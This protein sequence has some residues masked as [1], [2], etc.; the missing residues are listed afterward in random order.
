[1]AD[2]S[3]GVA[4]TVS[5]VPSV[6]NVT[7]AIDEG[8]RG[9]TGATGPE[10]PAGADGGGGGDLFNWTGG[11]NGAIAVA[12]YGVVNLGDAI[13]LPGLPDDAVVGTVI[14]IE[15]W[16]GVGYH[17]TTTTANYFTLYGG[18]GEQW[19]NYWDIDRLPSRIEYLTGYFTRPRDGKLTMEA[20]LV[21]TAT[22]N[23]WSLNIYLTLYY[24]DGTTNAQSRRMYASA[25]IYGGGDD[26]LP[27]NKALTI[28]NDANTPTPF[29]IYAA[30]MRRRT[31]EASIAAPV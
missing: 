7:L 29:Y 17:A 5:A 25:R 22:G 16:I 30:R 23:E 27:G 9:P 12:Q 13:G 3:D 10:G 21:D 18:F 31:D 1:M 28:V 2:D 11:W 20:T 24:S 4:V 15:L 26:D 6:L 19:Y 14:D 8:L